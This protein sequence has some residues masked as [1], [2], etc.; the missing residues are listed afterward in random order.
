MFD[1]KR[2]WP[3]EKL[4]DRLI[5]KQLFCQ[6]VTQNINSHIETMSL[7]CRIH[8]PLEN[9]RIFFCEHDEEEKENLFFEEAEKG[10]KS[11]MNST[12]SA[13]IFINFLSTEQHHH[14]RLSFALYVCASLKDISICT[15]RVCAFSK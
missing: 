8:F 14:Y 12:D 15:T 3:R 9:F 6:L 1:Y 5:D 10:Q 4:C 11:T 7:T 13:S 2:I